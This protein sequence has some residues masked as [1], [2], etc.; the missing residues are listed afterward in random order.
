[1]V[2]HDNRFGV[3]VAHTTDGVNAGV[4]APLGQGLVE[5]RPGFQGAGG[6][7][8]SGHAD[9]DFGYRRLLKGRSA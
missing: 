6:N 2:D 4:D 1:V 3:T 5:S 8:A 9:V 7:A